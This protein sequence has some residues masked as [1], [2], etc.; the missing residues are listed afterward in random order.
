MMNRKWKGGANRAVGKGSLAVW[1]LLVGAS[2]C[3]AHAARETVHIE[4]CL[5]AASAV[6]AGDYLK[7]E[8]LA[9]SPRG[10]PTYEIEV[11]G[12]DGREWEL[13]CDALTGTIYEIEQE[14]TGSSDPLFREQAKVSEEE[15]RAKALSIYP[16]VIEEVEY[17]LE[18]NGDASYEI[19]LV[20]ADGTEF[21]IE[22]DA[23]TGEIV[24]VS[25]EAWEIGQEANE[26]R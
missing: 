14:A 22:V 16:G 10:V 6:K 2:V 13:M 21:K 3:F 17:E 18:S 11:R 19:D 12:T 20:S 1:V 7:V 9:V 26:R 5:V 24:E 25:V 8:Y 23:A 4:T 15:A